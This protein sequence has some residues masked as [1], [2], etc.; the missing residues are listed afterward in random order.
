MKDFRI[1]NEAP[2]FEEIELIWRHR[3]FV[4]IKNGKIPKT[5][6]GTFSKPKK[7]R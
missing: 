1:S 3:L 7:H 5:F 6:A 4:G 2:S